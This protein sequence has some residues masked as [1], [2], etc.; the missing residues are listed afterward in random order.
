LIVWQDS[1]REVLHFLGDT[2]PLHELL[3]VS[4][5]GI[6]EA[7]Y[8]RTDEREYFVKAN[9]Q[10]NR[11]FF[12]KEADAL[13]L[14]RQTQA[15]KVPEVHGVFETEGDGAVFLVLEWVHGEKTRDTDER[16]GYGLAA[17]H[18]CFGEAF[19]L[20][21]DNYIGSLP[22]LNGWTADWVSFY[23]EKRLIPQIELGK[24]R[25]MVRGKRAK[26][27]DRLLERLPEWLGHAVKPSLLHGDLWGGNWI[28]GPGGEP[29][30]IDPAVY[31]GDRE[32]D[33]AF[34]ELFGGF[35]PRFYEAYREAYP[36]EP[37]YGE[38]KPL[39]QLYYLLVHLNLF[40]EAYG[41][42]VDRVLA[43]YAGG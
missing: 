40:G 1:I 36:L 14:I 34:T 20:T 15:V 8:V 26:Q 37:G 13:N 41:T 11:D 9:R 12:C 22:Q 5:G 33:L 16:L 21:K 7:F 39:Y 2:S 4:G 38:R 28:A 42:D 10:A 25:G 3:P 30:L 18:R 19:G 23:R 31:F 35:S 24:K 32:V 27:L 43:R 17:L 29:Y 6:N